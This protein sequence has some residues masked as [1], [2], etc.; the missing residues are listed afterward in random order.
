[1]SVVSQENKTMLLDLMVSICEENKY[2][3]NKKKLID[4]INS[5]CG[6]FHTQRFEYDNLNEIN[7]KIVELSYNFILSNQNSNNVS[8]NM[9]SI[10]IETSKEIFSRKLENQQNNFNKMINPKKPKEIDFTD[11]K[12]DEPIKNLDFI[13]TQTLADRQKELELITNKYNTNSQK[14]AQK[15]LNREDDEVPK[16]KIEENIKVNKLHQNINKKVRFDIDE[17]PSKLNNLFS[18]LKNKKISNDNNI[19]NMLETIIENQEKII[20]LLNKN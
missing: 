11:N 5:Q 19:K 8:S 15:W 4:F 17:K 10:K 12:E 9:N 16:I 13:M 6:Y 3:I 14:T 20:N 18:K 7:K 1:M 2:E